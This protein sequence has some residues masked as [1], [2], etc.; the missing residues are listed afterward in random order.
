MAEV[1]LGNFHAA[2]VA[3]VMVHIGPGVL[4]DC[5][6]LYLEADLVHFR[7]LGIRI[8]RFRN[9]ADVMQGQ[10]A[11]TVYLMHFPFVDGILPVNVEKP[12]HNGGHFP[13]IVIIK[14]DDADSH[15]VGDVVYALVFGAFEL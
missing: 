10:V 14:G 9:P 12:L 6:H 5:P 11:E 8:G 2:L 4:Q 7:M 3:G 13:Y 15:Q 1:Y